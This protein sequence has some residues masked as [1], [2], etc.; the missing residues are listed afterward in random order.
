MNQQKLKLSMK[1]N[2]A[3]HSRT[4]QGTGRLALPLNRELK[5]T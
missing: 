1:W 2:I 5:Q 4:G 3:K